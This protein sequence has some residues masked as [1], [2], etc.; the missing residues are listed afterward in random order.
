M[1][2]KITAVDD[3]NAKCPVGTEVRYHP[4]RGDMQS[5]PTRTRSA[6]W[7][8]CGHASV[9]IEGQAGSVSLE[10]LEVIESEMTENDSKNKWCDEPTETGW[11]WI[12]GRDSPAYLTHWHDHVWQD[13]FNTAYSTRDWV[14][15]G[16]LTP[17]PMPVKESK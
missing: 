11:Y 9:K 12:L 8:M 1:G 13:Q 2:V 16:P 3:W 6:A 14:F 15:C 5:D 17:P 4:V 10:H 7:E